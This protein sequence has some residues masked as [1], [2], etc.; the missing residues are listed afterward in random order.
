MGIMCS[1][2]KVSLNTANFYI[3]YDNE[4]VQFH[5]PN[6]VLY[7]KGNSAHVGFPNPASGDGYLSRGP[8]KGLHQEPSAP[9]EYS[10]PYLG[11]LEAHS[12]EAHSDVH[13][14]SPRSMQRR[15]AR[16]MK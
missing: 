10:T 15:R 13:G 14:R 7:Y 16:P 8:R 6:T 1:F 3:K 4:P 2:L 9:P 11:D 12:L 5:N